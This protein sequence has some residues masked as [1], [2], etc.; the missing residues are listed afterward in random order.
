MKTVM[1]TGESDRT[2]MP[3][4]TI[5]IWSLRTATAANRTV[6]MFAALLFTRPISFILCQNTIPNPLPQKIATYKLLAEISLLFFSLNRLT[7]FF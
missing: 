7:T 5:S 1:K 6:T 4:F 3:L 2:I